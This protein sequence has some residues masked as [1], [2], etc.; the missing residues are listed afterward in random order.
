[1]RRRQE[2][3]GVGLAS[4]VARSTVSSSRVWRRFFFL[5]IASEAVEEES[6]EDAGEGR[7]EKD[8]CEEEHGESPG[9]VC[10]A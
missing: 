2:V 5:L 1:M 4:M 9:L 10:R 8:E 6:A 3:G 7:E